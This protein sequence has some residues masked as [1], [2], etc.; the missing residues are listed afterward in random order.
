MATDEEG[1]RPAMDAGVA[2][3]VWSLEDSAQ[4]AWG[5][6]N[7]EGDHAVAFVRFA[8]VIGLVLLLVAFLSTPT[9]W[10]W[11]VRRVDDLRALRP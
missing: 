4:L 2:H 1:S 3:H 11:L 6:G 5:S 8:I 7:A 10:D 9:G